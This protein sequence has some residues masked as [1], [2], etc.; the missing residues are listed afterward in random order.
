MNEPINDFA[1]LNSQIVAEWPE[2]K[3]QYDLR[4]SSYRPDPAE[5]TPSAAVEVPVA[6]PAR[7]SS[8]V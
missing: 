1:K 3:R 2:W 7:E 4:V 5:S 6:E 8:L